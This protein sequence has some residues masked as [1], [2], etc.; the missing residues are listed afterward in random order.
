ME[1]PSG[2]YSVIFTEPRGKYP[3]LTTNTEVNYGYCFSENS[4]IIEHKNDD[5]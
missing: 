3:P 1:G 5:F 4:E 2:G